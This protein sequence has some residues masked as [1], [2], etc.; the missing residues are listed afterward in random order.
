MQQVLQVLQV[1]RVQRVQ[2]VQQVPFVREGSCA[3]VLARRY[4]TPSTRPELMLEALQ[5]GL[6]SSVAGP[7]ISGASIA[8]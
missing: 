1:Q 7:R 2:Q 5:K 8:D 4:A 3:A 6:V